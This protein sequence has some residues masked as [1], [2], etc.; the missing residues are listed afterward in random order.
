MNKQSYDLYVSLPA[1]SVHAGD[2]VIHEDEGRL[3][4][5][6]FRYRE[7]YL[8]HPATFPLD[9]SALPLQSSPIEFRDGHIPGFLDDYLPDDWGRR[10]LSQIAFYQ[11]RE[12]LNA[13]S[14]IDSLKMLS[15]S[16]IGGVSIVDKGA[17]PHFNHGAS[18]E[19]LALAEQAAIRL[20]E[21]Q[22]YDEATLLYLGNNGTGVGGARPKALLHDGQT[23]R[24]AKFNR[25][26]HDQYNSARVESACLKMAQQAGIDAPASTVAHGFNGREIVL[27]ERFDVNID[28]SRNHLVSINTLLRH[29]TTQQ[30]SGHAFTYNEIHRVMQRYVDQIE[31]S[32]EQLLLQMLFNRAINNTDDHQ[33]NFSL[34]HTKHGWS[35]SKAYDMVPTLTRGAFHAA[36]YGYDPSPPLV[37]EL[38][39]LKKAFGLSRE[40]IR[41]CTEQ[42][43]ESVSAW[44]D[45]ADH[46]KVNE[47]EIERIQ[48]IFN[49]PS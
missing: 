22:E 20:D 10:I 4:A 23:A 28:G 6:G 31:H 25:R 17:E 36:G 1:E 40:K 27:I 46:C 43:Y 34:I 13:N 21:A 35:L 3:Q 8:E 18:M 32:S 24:I 42:V 14:V 15:H 49:L 9:P 39:K 41:T 11:K 48:K 38:D 19:T 33:R 2:L 37:N 45:T 12:K 47:Q 16:R 7:S 5:V 29:P 30:N 44:A 26:Q